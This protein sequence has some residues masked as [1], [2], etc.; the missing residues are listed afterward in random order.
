MA[1]SKIQAAGLTADLIDETKLAD[2]SIDSEHYNDGSIDTEHLAD[3]AVTL[4]KLAAGTDG[5]IIS[6]DASGNPVAIGPGSDGQVLTSTGSG[7]PPAFENASSGGIS[8]IV[9]DTSPQ[10]GGDLDTN[11]FEISLDDSHKIKWGDSDDLQIFHNGSHNIIQGVTSGQD[12]YIGVQNEGD[13][14]GFLKSPD[15]EWMVRGIVGGASKL[16]FD[17]TEKFATTSGGASVAGHL[18]PGTN[19]S[20]NLGDNSNT[21]ALITLGDHGELRF[22][23]GQENG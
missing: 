3:D 7:S 16:Y 4:A 18:L 1:L 9:S 5:Q 10:L 23:N 11:S 15:T 17:G 19:N 21:W 8:D 22:G 6:W 14:A 13:E 12:V 20:F 2:N